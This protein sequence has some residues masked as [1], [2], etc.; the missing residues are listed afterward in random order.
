MSKI[1][2]Q[3]HIG[4]YKDIAYNSS[5]YFPFAHPQQ[6]NYFLLSIYD[7]CITIIIHVYMMYII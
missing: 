7:V 6:N 2:L 3:F 4:Q 5:V 1:H